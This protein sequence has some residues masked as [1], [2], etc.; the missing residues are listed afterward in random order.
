LLNSYVAGNVGIGTTNPAFKLHVDGTAYATGAAG[1][2]SDRRHKT[3]ISDLS[4]DA[5]EVVKDLRPVT[6]EWKDPQDSGMEGSQLGFIAQEVEE[7]LPEAV[8]TQE[9]EEQTKGLKYNALIPM[10][11]KAIQ[12]L[13][14][15][16][17]V[18]KARIE[19]LEAKIE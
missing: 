4:L 11:T 16:N 8:L 19:A 1:A 10:L 12:E 9:N 15:E 2:L 18:L 17:A 5:L 14:A 3:N 6:F 13:A 7:V